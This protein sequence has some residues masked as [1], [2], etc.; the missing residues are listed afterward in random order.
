MPMTKPTSEQVT[1]LAAGS[2]A[3]QR[4]AL[5]KLRDVVSVKDFGAVGDGVANDT[6]AIQAALN[7][8]SG[9]T[10]VINK[11]TN[12]YIAGELTIPSNIR[13]ELDPGTIIESN[14]T[15]LPGN[16]RLFN[17]S[18][19]NVHIVGY[20]ATLQMVK[21]G[22]SSEYNHGIYIIG[23]TGQI[24]IEG[25][26][27]NDSGGDG[28][29]VKSPLADVTFRDCR[30]N[31]NRR[32]G[33]SIVECKSFADYRGTYTGTTG[34]APSAGVDIEPNDPADILGPI[35]MYD[36]V[37]TANNGAGIE[38]F[39]D[40]WRS[41]TNYADIQ[42]VRP[43]TNGNGIASVSGRFR[44]GIDINRMASITPCR[45]RIQVIDAICENEGVAGIHVYD[46]DINGPLVQFVRPNVLNPNQNN[47]SNSAINGGIVLFNSGT[48][49]A[50]SGNVVVLQPLVRDDDN[51]LFSNSLAP[52][53][54]NGV[55]SATIIS[56]SVVF[57][58]TN[59][60][61]PD[62]VSTPTIRSANEL[63]VDTSSNLTMTD[64]RYVGRVL[65]NNG[66]SGTIAITLPVSKV[67]IVLSFCLLESLA[68]QITPN[69]AD[70][71]VPVGI[72]ANKYITANVRGSFI[73]L[74][75]RES[76]FWDM[77]NM[78]GTWTSQT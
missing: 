9:K 51:F 27:S 55:V 7:A 4:T 70:H 40:N 29:Y 49:T 14:A 58:G 26:A 76:G 12:K 16:K 17:I 34:T 11:P 72:A 21:A 31:N 52:F 68:V 77:E 13:I 50:N 22:F 60:W 75:C 25:I 53:R 35:R 8:A 69:A 33:V 67:G 19:T 15:L 63:R 1:F 5:D 3:T 39:L 36:T 24:V 30:A 37:A 78:S 42:I 6:V 38:I 10:L 32:Q 23:A 66:A 65:T 18:G 57:S 62:L 28:F 2:G 64:W 54:F 45:G 41:I 74:R 73:T 47:G 20:G 44:A 43:Y 46:W 56:P 59:P 48:Y 71:I 61:I